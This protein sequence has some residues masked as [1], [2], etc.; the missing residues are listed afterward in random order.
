MKKA[1][2]GIFLC[3]VMSQAGGGY[4]FADRDEVGFAQAL[5]KYGYFDHATEIIERIQSKIDPA[6]VNTIKAAMLKSQASQMMSNR[7]EPAKVIVTMDQAIKLYEDFIGSNAQS[8]KAISCETELAELYQLKA[9]QA[10]KVYK[11]STDAASKDKWFK[12]CESSYE[13]SRSHYKALIDKLSENAPYLD[14]DPNFRPYMMNRYN[15]ISI[16]YQQSSIYPDGDPST[17]KLC[18]E[19]LSY[20]EDFLWDYEAYIMMYHVRIVEAMCQYQLGKPEEAVLT[21][22]GVF[23]LKDNPDFWDHPAAKDII[24]LAYRQK[25]DVFLKFAERDNQQYKEVINTV[26]EMMGYVN[27]LVSEKRFPDFGKE[28]TVVIMRV[29]KAFARIKLG[30]VDGAMNDTSEISQI[31]RK[32]EYYIGKKLTEWGI[33]AD[34]NSPPEILRK[35]I[36]G[37]MSTANYDNAYKYCMYLV[38]SRK[39]S[40]EDKKE[41]LPYV[42]KRMSDIYMIKEQYYESAVALEMVY[43]TLKK[44]YNLTV[45]AEIYNAARCF[46][47]EDT[48]SENIYDK[49]RSE[50]LLKFLVEKYPN[51][52]YTKNAR[53]LVA[54]SLEDKKMFLEAAAEYSKVETD[55]E[56]YEDALARIGNCY[57]QYFRKMDKAGSSEEKKKYLDD[58]LKAFTMYTEY[59][60]KTPV[61]GTKENQ[62]RQALI[63]SC[64][65]TIA[66]IYL[67]DNVAR[68]K[69]ALELLA[70]TEKE[71]PGDGDKISR[72]WFKMVEAHLKLAD[73]DNARALLDTARQKY[74]AAPRLSYVLKLAGSAFD[75]SGT[76]IIEKDKK[77]G[78]DRIVVGRNYLYNWF[79]IAQSK[80]ENMKNEDLLAL[81]DKMFLMAKDYFNDEKSKKEQFGRAIRIYETVL[82]KGN[83]DKKTAADLTW[84]IGET[85]YRL[86]DY[87]NAKKVFEGLFE[88]T[89]GE[90]GE[91]IKTLIN[92][93]FEEAVDSGNTEHPGF[94]TAIGLCTK[95]VSS[96][97]KDKKPELWW[98]LK[99]RQ[100]EILFKQGKYPVVINALKMLTRYN[101]DWDKSAVKSRIDELIKNLK[102]RGWEG[103]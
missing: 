62:K 91:V 69:D 92:I 84:K 89:K 14:D 27:K 39:M 82:N 95:I 41:H 93:N 40:N 5:A 19:S 51:S 49:K 21:L 47:K 3:A 79:E 29:D 56:A 2:I 8:S 102:P 87:A 31:D 75:Q 10:Q 86:K 46:K 1:M 72:A 53:V 52:S 67:D 20:V 23:D 38:K 17:Q 74:P 65:Y 94:N 22:K 55:A 34:P 58:A 35:M 4:L 37:S 7:E 101:P 59:T 43:K 81:A 96:I 63:F 50:S 45:D 73:Y 42:F 36:E 57:Y 61:Y 12:E 16:I 64:N 13:Q 32:W 100:C 66:T 18:E 88:K 85:S 48:L 33:T 68:Y 83:I 6:E 54:E 77:T 44:R 103:N 78:R 60:K 98:E 90:D 97:E 9:T 30:D 25:I 26:D 11:D 28:D 80:N 76:E 71:Y 24:T 99:V 70:N 15:L